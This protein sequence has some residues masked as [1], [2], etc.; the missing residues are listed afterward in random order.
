[1]EVDVQ[2]ALQGDAQGVLER[3]LEHRTGRIVLHRRLLSG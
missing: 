2:V 3:E 1:L